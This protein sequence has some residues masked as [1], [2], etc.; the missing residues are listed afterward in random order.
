MIR[1]RSSIT[2]VEIIVNFLE[3]INEATARGAFGLLN[4]LINHILL[5]Q[6]AW[7]FAVAVLGVACY[8][9]GKRLRRF[10]HPDYPLLSP[11]VRLFAGVAVYSAGLVVGGAMAL[12]ALSVVI[13]IVVGA[14]AQAS[15][16]RADQWVTVQ[17]YFLQVWPWVSAPA[18]GALAGTAVGSMLSVVLTMWTIPRWERGQGLRDVRHMHKLFSR[19]KTYSPLSYVDIDKGIFVG[20]ED[21][22]HPVYIPLGQFH[23][24]HTQVIGASGSGKGIALGLLAYQFA[25][26]G[27]CVI[28]M[29][30]KGDKRLPMVAALAA[31]K[32]GKKFW[33]LDLR[34]ESPPQFN[35][36]AGAAE[37]EI[38]EL[39][40]AGLGLQ[41]TAGA[42]DYYRGIDQ[43]AAAAV[44]QYA[45]SLDKPGVVT[46]FDFARQNSEVAKAENFVRRLGQVAQLK[47]IQTSH[48]LD[49]PGLIAR[50]DVLYIRGS[51][52]NYRVKSLQ[53]MLL[54]RLLQVI[55]SN[56]SGR[57]V[58]LFMDEFKHL[59]CSVSLDALGVAREMG[60][61][62]HAI[63]AHQSM[64]D[65]GGC[66]GLRREDV[67][68]RVVDNT[69]LKL[70]YRLNDANSSADF[71]AR[72][73]TQRTHAEGIRG[74]DQ[75]NNDQRTWT[76]VPQ[77]RMSEDLFTHLHRPTD[78]KEVVAAGVLFGYK[79]ARLLAVA[80]INVKGSAPS[81]I[82]A[83]PE[84]II[85]PKSVEA[86][87]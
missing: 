16:Q 68:P 71:A 57:K 45:T 61:G 56:E 83:P 82:A 42:G 29:D 67:E 65:L 40:V 64:G 78:G 23:E 79:T 38:E 25:L 9:T 31:K 18:Y 72:S 33:F 59:L 80:P 75:D 85:Q 44:A 5:W 54:I 62:C 51:T 37:H 22:R 52:D 28:V 47:A 81:V 17:H 70:V 46:L 86:L 24:T 84:S 35:L 63:L 14:S 7:F 11:T 36:L 73:G 20:L 48:N 27:E 32:A 8:F 58:A 19:M 21:G 4:W 2:L 77:F 15:L 76:E 12:L 50:G 10:N 26:S 13:L 3:R 43:D 41:P 30:P 66:P 53:T 69:T 6:W 60:S 74:L 1:L 87:I 34:P 39:L 49:L 55:K